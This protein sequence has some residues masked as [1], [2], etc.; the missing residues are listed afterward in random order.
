MR[1]RPLFTAIT[2]RS[3]MTPLSGN[4]PTLMILNPF[5]LGHF[6]MQYHIDKIKCLSFNTFTVEKCLLTHV[7]V[8]SGTHSCCTLAIEKYQIYKLISR[9]RVARYELV[10]L[11]RWKLVKLSFNLSSCNASISMG[12]CISLIIRPKLRLLKLWSDF[13]VRA[14]SRGRGLEFSLNQSLEIS[15]SAFL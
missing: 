4:S 8:D 6:V 5:I 10:G 1:N 11:I 7:G 14:I 3:N 9:H 12:Y 2:E 13:P 15:K